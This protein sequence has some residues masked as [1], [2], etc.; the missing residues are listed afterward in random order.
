MLLFYC[1]A[2]ADTLLHRGAGQVTTHMQPSPAPAAQEAA[3][4]AAAAT[5]GGG[6][7]AA[8]ASVK[9]RRRVM[10]DAGAIHKFSQVESTLE[11]VFGSEA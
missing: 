5:A 11:R 9:K 1:A 6:E 4:A 2:Y 10:P 3:G 7:V 8:L